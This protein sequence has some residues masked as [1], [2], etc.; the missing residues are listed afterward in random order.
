MK[1][2]LKLQAFHSIFLF[3][4]YKSKQEVN[5][6]IR[7]TMNMTIQALDCLNAVHERVFS[8]QEKNVKNARFSYLNMK[9][10][11]RYIL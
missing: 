1:D 11:H 4:F 8:L 2:F 5:S 9:N 7:P 6:I 3:R 10:L